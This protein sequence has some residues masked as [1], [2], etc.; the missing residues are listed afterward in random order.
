LKIVKQIIAEE[1]RSKAAKQKTLPNTKQ[2][3]QRKTE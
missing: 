3:F 1:E 2:T